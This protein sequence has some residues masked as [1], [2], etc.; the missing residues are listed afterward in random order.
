MYETGPDPYCYP[1]TD[2]LRN[3]RGTRDQA[4]L[5]L[6]EALRVEQ[7]RAEGLPLIPSRGFGYGYYRR[8]HR[9]LFGDVYAWAGR[10]RT[11]RLT[12]VA[13]TFCYP[14]H[15]HSEMGKLFAWLAAENWLADLPADRFAAKTAHFLAELNAIHPFREGNGRPQNAFLDLLASRA[16]HPLDMSRIDTEQRDVIG[17]MIEAFN[18]REQPLAELILALMR[19]SR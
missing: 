2:V 6:F 16:G 3:L 11:V 4:E 19:R 1:G 12:K 17:P 5:A 8:V 14:E 13:S 15:I 9:H 7:R 10:I 18:G